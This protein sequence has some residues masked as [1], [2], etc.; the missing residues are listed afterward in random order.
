[1]EEMLYDVTAVP[2]RHAGH[3]Q[4]RQMQHGPQID[5]DQCIDVFG[6]RVQD[7]TAPGL[8]GIVDQHVEL[9]RL[10]QRRQRVRVAHV[11]RV[12]PAPGLCR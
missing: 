2:V 6:G 5:V 12:H 1:M 10:R 7:V 8:A 9:G 4:P 11:H 3:D